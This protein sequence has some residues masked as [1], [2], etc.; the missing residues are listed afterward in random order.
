MPLPGAQATIRTSTEA[1]REALSAIIGNLRRNLRLIGATTLIGAFLVTV[2]VTL[3]LTPQYMATSTLLVD[4]RKTQILKDQEVIGRPGT[5]SSAIE[6]EAEMVASPSILR[7]VAADLHL[8]QDEEFSNAPAGLF[9]WLKWLLVAP[10]KLVLGGSEGAA[11][12]DPFD[13]VVEILQDRVHAKR[14]NLTY[15][16]ELSAWSRSGVRAA[17]LANAVAEAYLKDQVGEKNEA[18]RKATGWLTGELEQLRTRLKASEDAYEKYKAEAGLFDTNGQ[19][20]ADRNISQL[21][22]QLL[23]ARAQEAEAEAKYGQLKEVNADKLRS[24]AASPDI[25]QSAVLTNLRNQYADVARKRAELTT[26]YGPRHPQVISVQAELSNLTKQIQEELNRIVSSAHTELQMAK[27]RQASLAASLEELKAGASEYN[28]KAVKLRELEREAQANR[29]LFEAFLSRAKETAAQLNM[30]MPDLRILAAAVPPRLPGFPRKSL[31]IGLGVFGSLGLG[32]FL[33][34]IRGMM[35]E[36]IRS[37]SELQTA[38]GLRPLATIPLVEPQAHRAVRRTDLAAPR[39]IPTK[40]AQLVPDDGAAEARRL[41]EL[42][43]KEPNS[44]F[45]E[46]IH[47]LRLALRQAAN[48]RQM[49]VILVTSALPGEG[50]STI[51]ANLARAAAMY[52]ERVLLIDGDLRRPSVAAMFGL[53]PSP[54]LVSLVKGRCGL[55][56]AIHRDQ[57]PDLHL[58]AGVNRVTGSD[59]LTL[60]ASREF[61]RLLGDLRANYDLILIDSS[62][63]AAGRRPAP[64]RQPGRWRCPDRRLRTDQP[65]RRESGPAGHTWD[66]DQNPRCGDEPRARRFCAQL[67]GIRFLQQGRLTMR[68]IVPHFQANKAK[69]GQALGSRENL[70]DADHENASAST[71][72]ESAFSAH[73]LNYGKPGKIAVSHFARPKRGLAALFNARTVPVLALCVE[74]MLVAGASFAAGDVYHRF[75]IGLLPYQSFYLATTVL[76]AAIFTVSCGLNR[77]YSLTRLAA[78]REQMRSV[79][80]HWNTAYLLLAFALFI[81]HATEFYSR[82]STVAQYFA[83][84]LV[85]L[86]FRLLLVRLVATNLNKGRLGGKRIVIAGDAASVAYVAR[87]LRT[88]EQGIEIVGTVG[89]PAAER[90]ANERLTNPRCSRGDQRDRGH[91]PGHHSG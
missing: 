78:P 42:V 83:G 82:G 4:S 88:D 63:F 14:R 30:Q 80:L 59:A 10:I 1:E 51:A 64:A 90:M 61:E 18:T 62:T 12:T 24:A 8:D 72:A 13:R 21:N 11:T 58:I 17:D 3:V 74:F 48:E 41:G 66:R 38:F 57:N 25:L 15:V 35:S 86:G 77:D 85:A 34:L 29:T 20:L 53:P 44:P 75:T 52:G 50:K 68:D 19:N 22:E 73:I 23:M 2:L 43:V 60:L 65:Q 87:R 46:S 67:P 71:K 28:L 79:F 33:A 31:M 55:K 89:F 69:A 26:R 81:V 6:S 49:S 91:C 5:E 9:G 16:I 56:D 32:I 70:E 36:S 47:S 54:G 7:R 39:A 45:S 76:L 84:A 37:A 27:S 40:L